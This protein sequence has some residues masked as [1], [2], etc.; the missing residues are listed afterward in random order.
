MGE[1]VV[2]F[3]YFKNQ[4]R[5]RDWTQQ[6]LAEFYRVE[7]TLVQHALAVSTDRGISDE[8]DPW[9]IFCRADDEEVIAH[10]ARIGQQYVVVSSAF[11]GVARGADF[12]TLIQ[13]LM[14]AHPLMLPSR[15]G[16]AKK[17]LLHPTALLSA[18]VATAFLISAEKGAPIEHVSSAEGQ[19]SS[20]LAS[21]LQD[22]IAILSAIA[23]AASFV[24]KQVELALNLPS[25]Q[26]SLAEHGSDTEATVHLAVSH[27]P[28]N[29]ENS[30]PLQD[31][32]GGAHKLEMASLPSS[33][34]GAE[35]VKSVE[36]VALTQSVVVTAPANGLEK[37]A[38]SGVAS[39]AFDLGKGVGHD[40][41][42]NLA[43]TIATSATTP[44]IG[45]ELVTLNSHQPASVE[46]D[47]TS[48][49]TGPNGSSDVFNLAIGS[50]SSSQAFHLVAMD[51]GSGSLQ[52][53]H[54]PIIV[55]LSGDGVEQGLLQIGYSAND[56][57]AIGAVVSIDG[58]A[59][60]T[61]NAAPE[62]ASEAAAGSVA[63]T[64]DHTTLAISTARPTFDAQANQ[65]LQAFLNSTPQIAM[66]MD[67]AGKN[68]ILIDSNP[69]DMQNHDFHVVEWQVADGSTLT[70]IGILPHNV[71]TV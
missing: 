49:H 57:H 31:A 71:T 55:P 28:T 17:V 38:D 33:V 46:L 25:D 5:E 2:F 47:S 8:G 50:S 68:L 60:I 14:E 18:L 67:A 41:G 70:L 4:F 29:A 24:E 34:L 37:I 12:R 21:L 16:A 42:I 10:V 11:S 9:F 26:A 19:K 1:L 40:I 43:D 61:A 54:L 23:I 65:T 22:K 52:P 30:H 51:L 62:P 64:S 13:S 69:A 35:G 32:G 39:S 66:G 53:E 6:E 3:S 48:A 7:N 45:P 20:F 56:A 44:V 27:G 63:A 15:S 36:Q 59:T 58:N